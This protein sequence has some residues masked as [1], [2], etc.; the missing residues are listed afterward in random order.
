VPEARSGLEGTV[1]EIEAKRIDVA[2]RNHERPER[3]RGFRVV[4]HRAAVMIGGQLPEHLSALADA[5]G[6]HRLVLAVT[7]APRS[8]DRHGDVARDLGGRLIALV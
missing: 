6:D 4:E 7:L 1:L 3:M 2:V 8:H 5:Q